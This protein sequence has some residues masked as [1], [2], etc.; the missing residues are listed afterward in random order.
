M[1]R[2]FGGLDRKEIEASTT[3]QISVMS[4]YFEERIYIRELT[5]PCS[6]LYLKV[7][8]YLHLNTENLPSL[9]FDGVRCVAFEKILKTPSTMGLHMLPT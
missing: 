8:P 5:G 9:E 2:R 3:C 6:N 4:S 1:W 7:A